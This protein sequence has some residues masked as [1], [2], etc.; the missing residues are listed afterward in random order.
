MHARCI[1]LPR[2]KTEARAQPVQRLA[3][4]FCERLVVLMIDEYSLLIIR[5]ITIWRDQVG[6]R[7][8]RD[9]RLVMRESVVY[10]LEKNVCRE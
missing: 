4:A 5:S 6:G 2:H 1:Q 7:I 3:L 8:C 10:D 9:L